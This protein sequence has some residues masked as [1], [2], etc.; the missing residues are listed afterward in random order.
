M[1]KKWL[2]RVLRVLEESLNVILKTMRSHY[3]ISSWEVHDLVCMLEALSRGS[4]ED[5]L[6]R[7][8]LVEQRSVGKLLHY[9]THEIL[10]LQSKTATIGMD[11]KP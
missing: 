7:R 6:R 1:G 9:F 10:R 2:R 11:R 3:T 5:G 4:V 8:A